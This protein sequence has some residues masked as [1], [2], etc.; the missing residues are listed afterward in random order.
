[1][2]KLFTGIVFL[3]FVV[4]MSFISQPIHSQVNDT[5]SYPFWIEM[6]QNPDVNF[7]Q[8]VKAFET[9]W[10]DREITKGS[11]F[12]PFKRWEYWTGQRVSPE[13][14]FLHQS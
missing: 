5:A 2:K 11:G 3:F 10:Q 4:I 7:F 9:Y 8:T 13:G 14:K 6:M 12:K 1:M